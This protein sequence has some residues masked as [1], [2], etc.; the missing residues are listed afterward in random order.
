MPKYITVNEYI[1][2]YFTEKSRPSPQ[3]VRHWIKRRYISGRVLG[4]TYYVDI[5]DDETKLDK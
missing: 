4:R 1:S 3:A 2:S 5:S